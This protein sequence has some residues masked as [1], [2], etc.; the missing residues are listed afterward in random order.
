MSRKAGIAMSLILALVFTFLIVGAS[1]RKYNEATRSVEVAQAVRYIPV[2]TELT[3]DDM[4]AVRV[5]KSAAKGLASVK[6]ALGKTAK[7]PML[8]GQYVYRDALDTAKA[9]RPGYVEVFVPVDLSSSACSFSGQTVN[10][11]I[12]DKEGKVAPMVLENVHV[13]HSLTSQGQNVGEK[14]GGIAG[15]AQSG[16]PASVGVEV[17]KDKAEIV[18]QAAAAKQIYLVRSETE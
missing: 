1:N 6:E 18:V 4:K 14:E 8:K 7:V 13:L 11:H 16:G 10:V 12:V 17:P 2:G 3:E 5:V 15:G 9:L